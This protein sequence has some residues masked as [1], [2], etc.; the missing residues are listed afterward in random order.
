M[1]CDIGSARLY[2]PNPKKYEKESDRIR[3]LLKQFDPN[4]EVPSSDEFLLDVTDYLKSHQM[5]DDIG[6]IFLGDKIRKII[7][8]NTKLTASCGVASNK[9]LS[10]IC[11]DFNKPNGLTFL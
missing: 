2:R 6:R 1:G 9:L 3:D 7:Y 5:E 11:S 8:E 10:K 4:L